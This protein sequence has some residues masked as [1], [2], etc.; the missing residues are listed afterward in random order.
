MPRNDREEP[1][2][3]EAIPV[4]RTREE[5]LAGSKKMGAEIRR[6]RQVA[7]LT[8]EELSKKCSRSKGQLSKI[9]NGEDVPGRATWT[10][11]ETVELIASA[12]GVTADYLQIIRGEPA[13]NWN[14]FEWELVG[15]YRNST[16]VD[17]ELILALVRAF[18]ATRKKQCVLHMDPI[19]PEASEVSKVSLPRMRFVDRNE[20]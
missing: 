14:Q 5:R 9:E 20:L 2:A 10:P 16:T 7:R 11:R 15:Y 17:Q 3:A 1:Q 19:A 12:L 4:E 8:L 6:L 13:G 18:A